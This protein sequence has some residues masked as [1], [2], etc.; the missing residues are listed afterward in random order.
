MNRDLVYR[1]NYPEDRLLV[2]SI[3]GQPTIMAYPTDMEADPFPVSF[4]IEGEARF[5]TAEWGYLLMGISE[6]VRV[7]EL[8]E[9]A[10]ELHQKLAPY[11]QD[12]CDGLGFRKGWEEAVRSSAVQI[13][14]VET[15][16]KRE[17]KDAYL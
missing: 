11:F 16:K 3:Q 10:S 4:P 2:L 6:L 12:D 14:V 1:S 17:V 13:F 5:E 8:I 9:E 15:E 7:Q